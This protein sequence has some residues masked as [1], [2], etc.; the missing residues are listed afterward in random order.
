MRKMSC[1]TRC[2][3]C[4]SAPR[5]WLRSGSDIAGF[6]PMMYMPLISS[7]C[8]ASMISTTVLPRLGSSVT[9]HAASYLR[10]DLGIL[11]RLVV[12]EE[13]RD[14]AGIGGA[15]HVVLAA[16]RMQPGA[17]PAD[18]AA[19]Q[20]QRDQAARVVGAVGVLRHAHAPEDDGALG[21]REGARDVA[22]HVRLDAADRR[23]LLGR[24]RLHAFGELVEILGVGLDVLLVVE[25][26]G[27]DDVEHAR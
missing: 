3:R 23:H 14:Q 22:Q 13:H 17:G 19:D 26:L 12:G 6:S 25:L 4:A 21:A 16:Q 7:A 20:R 9:P 1:T 5:A 8:T 2:S 18:L 27:D 11:H 10:A 15:L 24:E